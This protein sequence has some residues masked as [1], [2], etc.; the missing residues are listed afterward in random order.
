MPDA[1]PPTAWDLAARP[2]FLIRRLHQIHLAMFA[3]ECAG[4]GIT[5]VQF[6]ILSV[7][8]VQPGLD[9]ARLG[10]EVGVDRTTLAN[11]VARMEARGLVVRTPGKDRRLKHVTLTEAGHDLLARI[12]EPARRAH[13]RTVESLPEPAREAFLR[14]LARLVEAGNGYGRA[15]L[16]LG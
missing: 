14:A 2:G 16:R 12:E 5:P 11:V 8:A 7:A 10:H 6:S 13:A 3:E 4:F 9:Q 1:L 15:P